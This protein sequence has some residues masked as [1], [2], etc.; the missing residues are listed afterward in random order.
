M[1]LAGKKL[2][3][4]DGCPICW[5]DSS[6]ASVH[7]RFGPY[8]LVVCPL[9]DTEYLNPRATEAELAAQYDS[10]T[11]YANV[12]GI[13]GY[14]D[15]QAEELAIRAI[16]RRR[17]IQARQWIT[18]D[19]LLEIGGA[20]GYGCDQAQSMGYT[21]TLVE[22]SASAREAAG[23]RGIVAMRPDQTKALPDGQ[24]DVVMAWDTLEHI[25]DLQGMIMEIHRLLKPGGAFLFNVPTITSK[26][27]RL[28]GRHW[29]AYREPEHVI[30]LNNRSIRLLLWDRFTLQGTWHDPQ[31]R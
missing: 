5:Y 21:A 19:K 24:V 17:L 15:Y 27:A 26:S 30:Y 8:C 13:H 25:Y 28:F 9:C 23:K 7:H 31:L 18:G 14:F 4:L 20:L 12:D 6:G 11:Y 10:P 16:V 2:E 3:H 22:I 1:A 29:W